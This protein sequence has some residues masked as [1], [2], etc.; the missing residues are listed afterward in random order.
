[1]RAYFFA[2]LVSLSLAACGGSAAL[3][4]QPLWFTPQAFDSSPVGAADSKATVW[5]Y[6]PPSASLPTASQ[7]SQPSQPTATAA[8]TPTF[9][10]RFGDLFSKPGTRLAIAMGNHQADIVTAGGAGETTSPQPQDIPWQA[11]SVAAD[12]PSANWPFLDYAPLTRPLSQPDRIES[13]EQQERQPLQARLASSA[14]PIGN[15]NEELS[16]VLPIPA[17]KLDFPTQVKPLEVA[18]VQQQSTAAPASSASDRFVDPP[19]PPRAEPPALNNITDKTNNIADKANKPAESNQADNRK[20]KPSTKPVMESMSDQTPLLNADSMIGP[21]ESATQMFS[22]LDLAEDLPI[23]GAPAAPPPRET[24]SQF[25]WSSTAFTWVSPAFYHYPLYFE[26]P[27]LERY[28]I[29]R[30]RLVQP[31]LSSTHFF[32]SIPLVPYKSLTNHPRERVYTLGE[33]RPGNRVPVQRGVILGP[34]K[35]NEALMFR[36]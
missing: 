12:S 17:D 23:Y 30:A 20:D 5:P 6:A 29:G 34:S 22:R 11:N 1:M 4:Q 35:L 8:N 16:L 15:R 32:W 3:A 10:Q 26:Q 24:A 13:V 19:E 7:P 36:E 25:L 21:M 2:G 9:S 18:S 14:R 27:N 31:L 28:G 33:G